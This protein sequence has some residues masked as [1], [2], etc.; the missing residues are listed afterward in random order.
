MLPVDLVA[1]EDPVDVIHRLPTARKPETGAG[2]KM[3]VFEQ[4]KRLFEASP[5][6]LCVEPEFACQV[7]GVE[8]VA[9]AEE[10]GGENER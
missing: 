7:L 1:R 4:R 9:R 8:N 3:L 6:G 5:P 2:V 10:V